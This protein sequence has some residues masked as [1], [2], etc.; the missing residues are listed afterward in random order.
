[1]TSDLF[2]LHVPPMVT[3]IERGV[4]GV[5][6]KSHEVFA[7]GLSALVAFHIAGA[8]RHH[9]HLEIDILRADDGL[10]GAG[11]PAA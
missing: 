9:F 10:I 11:H 3:N 6:E 8:L 4:R 2:G 5:I 1:M 7:Y